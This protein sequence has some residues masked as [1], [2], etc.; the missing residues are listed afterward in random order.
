VG[1]N[2]DTATRTTR[3]QQLHPAG[4]C[5]DFQN[6]ENFKIHL[7]KV[8]TLLF[9]FWKP[10]VCLNGDIATQ[11]TGNLEL[12]PPGNCLDFQNFENVKIHLTVLTPLFSFWKHPVALNGDSATRTTRNQQLHSA[13]NC[14]CLDFQNLKN[15]KIHLTKVLTPLFLF[16]KPPVA[17]NGD[18][19]TRTTRKQ[20]LHPAGNCL[21]FQNFENFKIH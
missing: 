18:T 3:N 11:A 12:H 7:T 6:L 21:D 5:L 4:N 10:P 1:L 8:L 9:L 16:W 13:G 19:V 2:G 14:H 20:Q 15:F 17:L